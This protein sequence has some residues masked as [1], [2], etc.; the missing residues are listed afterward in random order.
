MLDTVS[1][2]HR[3]R[4]LCTPAWG[5]PRRLTRERKGVASWRELSAS[6]VVTTSLALGGV[7]YPLHQPSLV[8]REPLWAS[9]GRIGLKAGSKL[10]YS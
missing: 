10:S 1:D 2:S 8:K 3:L 4:E 5:H 9:A 6:L 7:R